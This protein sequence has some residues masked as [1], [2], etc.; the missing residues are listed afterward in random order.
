MAKAVATVW[1]LEGHTKAKH[2]LLTRYLSRWVPIFQH[3][4]GRTNDLVL[5]D[6]F[7]GP[8]IYEGGEPGSPV[9]MVRE[10]LKAPRQPDTTLH[11]FFIE[12]N[13]ARCEELEPRVSGFRGPQ[14]KIHV[15]L[16]DYAEH[17]DAIRAHV[18]ALR[19]PAVFAFLDPFS[20][21][22]DPELA[23]DVVVRPTSEA[24][25]YLPVGHFARFI[26]QPKMART[27]NGVFGDDRWKALKGKST[28]QI[29]TGLVRLYSER[30]SERPEPS[31]PRIYVEH[32]AIQPL[33]GNRYYLFFAT[34][35]RKAVA[36]MREAMWHVDPA[37]GRL[38]D[39]RRAPQ[40]GIEDWKPGL[41]SAIHERFPKG[42]RFYFEDAWQF[43]VEHHP[44]FDERRLRA[45]LTHLRDVER[46]IQVRDPQTGK[47]SRRGFP[48]G[49]GIDV[50]A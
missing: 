41:A 38:F 36:A 44:P 31:A 10:Y 5:I 22:D 17:Y 1:A 37:N 2:E 48:R 8:G 7:A 43:V 30:L 34:K 46:V 29:T 42:S 28:S 21:L 33:S 27:L 35:H 47:P 19:D 4:Y 9:L 24:L 11:C 6:G 14:C 49:R 40:P 50:I 39:A 13:R 25:V 3:G 18:D 12:K 16:G 15:L 20:A 26:D 32:F 23:V 45:A